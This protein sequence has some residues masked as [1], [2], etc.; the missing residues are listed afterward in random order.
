[1]ARAER[2]DGW[3]RFGRIACGLHWT[4][5]LEAMFRRIACVPLSLGV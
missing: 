2:W 4:R 5:R 1:M 3:V